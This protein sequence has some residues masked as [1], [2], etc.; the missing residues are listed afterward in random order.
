MFPSFDSLYKSA[1]TSFFQFL[2]NIRKAKVRAARGSRRRGTVATLTTGRNTRIVKYVQGKNNLAP[3]ETVLNS[4]SNGNYDLKSKKLTITNGDILGWTRQEYESLTLILLVDVS[5]STW[6]F[7]KT[8]KEILRSLT[9]YF[10]KHN[11]RVGLVSLQGLQAKIYSH[12]TNNFRVVARGL[13]KLKFHGET[14][15]AD[16]LYKSLSMARLEN[17]KNPG[18]KSIVVLLS[19]CYPEPLTP[20]CSNIFDDPA[21]R[22]SINAAAQYR[23]GNTMLLVI[24]PA[25]DPNESNLPGETLSENM[26]EVSGGKLIKLFRSKDERYAKPSRKEIEII[27]KG[28]EESLLQVNRS[29]AAR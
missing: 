23:K 19:D 12:P 26:A 3:F 2:R 9:G 5:K 27:V 13:S 22:N 15:I 20:G 6:P 18:S 14:P 11:D 28:V 16:G 10:D 7:I 4:I 8:F 17:S 29:D 24:N 1:K 25:F 21:Y